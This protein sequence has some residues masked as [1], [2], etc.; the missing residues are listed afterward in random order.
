[1][2][3]CP[4]VSAPILAR[5]RS[6]VAQNRSS[7]SEADGVKSTSR[8]GSCRRSPK[9]HSQRPSK[10]EC[11]CPS[12]HAMVVTGTTSGSGSPVNARTSSTRSTLTLQSSAIFAT[13][14]PSA[15]CRATS[16]YSLAGISGAPL[17]MTQAPGPYARGVTAS[18]RRRIDQL[19]G[20][21]SQRYSSSPSPCS[22]TSAIS[23][24]WSNCSSRMPSRSVR[25]PSPLIRSPLVVEPRANPGVRR[26]ANGSPRGARPN[27]RR[28]T[29]AADHPWA[30]SDFCSRLAA[31]RSSSRI[32]WAC[33]LIRRL[34]LPVVT[35]AVPTS[36]TGME[37]P[38]TT[39][40]SGQ[41][42]SS[43]Q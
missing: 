35:S 22:R 10:S 27:S 4:S 26:E 38:R 23:R 20:A 5:W 1:M 7:A 25:G 14:I 36:D 41:S 11:R 3:S 42:R 39:S 21:G 13:D 2:S 34:T 37:S 28:G 19:P 8:C 6:R 31:I 33:P 24:A 43:A 30:C 16:A 18:S 15:A 9:V 12:R 40:A 17:S 32:A 29:G